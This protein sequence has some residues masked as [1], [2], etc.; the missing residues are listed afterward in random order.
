MS[1]SF[2]KSKE[3][4]SL[5]LRNI[6]NKY[7]QNTLLEEIQAAGFRPGLELDFF[8][9]PMDK[10]SCKNKGYA[11]L[12][13]TTAAYAAQF[14]ALFNGRPL[15]KYATRKQTGVSDCNFQGIRGLW[16]YYRRQLP[17]LA[18]LHVTE[19]R[20][21]GLPLF[22]SMSKQACDIPL[23]HWT[24]EGKL[25]RVY[26]ALQPQAQLMAP[27]V[28]ASNTRPKAG[29]KGGWRDP[30]RI[31]TTFLEDDEERFSQTSSISSSMP[32]TPGTPAT[33]MKLKHGFVACSLNIEEVESRLAAALSRLATEKEV[34]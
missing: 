7:D 25:D 11:F 22:W 34:V 28:A 8:H 17:E 24:A 9:V 30:M 16:Y 13:F 33:P 18:R 5:M 26:P 20:E 1:P 4:T 27:V 6:A 3:L 31:T 12:N 14:R 2:N 15:A 29:T 21:N 23:Y 32:S 10:T 19:A